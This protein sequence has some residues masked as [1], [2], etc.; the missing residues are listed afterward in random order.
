MAESL[1]GSVDIKRINALLEKVLSVAD[2]TEYSTIID[3]AS[4]L[5]SYRVP[6]DKLLAFA[7]VGAGYVVGPASAINNGI[8]V[9]DTISGKLIKDS[10]VLISDL[11]LISN[12]ENTTLDTS[13]TKY[14]TN[15]LVKEY[16]D[17][18]VVGL[19]DDRGNYNASGNVF[20]ST[21]GSGTAGAILKG[22]IWYIS[23]GGTLG[24]SLVGVGD[25]VRALSDTPGQASTNWDILETN[26]GYIPE[27]AAN[28]DASGGYVGLTGYAHNFWN[29]AKTFLTTVVGTATA[30][31]AITLPNKDGMIAL[32]DDIVGGASITDQTYAQLAVLESGSLLVKG[33]LYRVTN[34]ITKHLIP[35]TSVIRSASAIEPLIFMAID[36]NKFA[37]QAYSQL[38]PKDIIHYNFD[39]NSCEDGTWSVPLQRYTG[40]TAR[41]GKITY[42]KDTVYNLETHYDWRNV[43]FR[44]WAVD[45]V[46]WASGSDYYNGDVAKGS[47]GHIYKCL[48]DISGGT[49][50]PVLDTI[51][52]ML[53]LKRSTDL[54]F[55]SW[56]NDTSSF[57]VFGGITPDNLI[58]RDTTPGTDFIDLYTFCISDELTNS[59]GIINGTGAGSVGYGFNFLS[60]GAINQG[61]FEYAALPVKGGYNNIVFY[62]KPDTNIEKICNNNYFGDNCYNATI[63]AYYM[64]NNTIGTGFNNNIIF[65]TCNSNNV[66]ITFC[67]NITNNGFSGN[68]IA[69][70]CN[71]NVF[72]GPFTQNSIGQGFLGNLI[73]NEFIGNNIA[74][75]V[76][77]NTFRGQF[78]YNKVNSYIL[79]IVSYSTIRD[80]SFEANLDLRFEDLSATTILQGSYNKTVFKN[81]A[82]AYRLSYINGANAIINVA[83]GS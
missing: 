5:T 33:Q 62:L 51:N 70:D 39:D 22:D 65:K 76:Y 2:L 57:S 30:P 60:L 56:T 64:Y 15:R 12:K 68:V 46:A 24:G 61:Y 53:L 10:A 35:N 4:D 40:G 20:P 66:G 73:G 29:A 27:N 28:K 75:L 21:G 82:G 11:E 32:L 9:F 83:V 49:T 78:L 59:S 19:L 44:R 34:H 42:R 50:N 69:T 72:S 80:T 31:R 3:K 7:G 25:S 43:K 52:W 6:L 8:A 14:P 47:D 23:V 13:A 67:N 26:I 1:T 55:Q 37:L 54:P 74:Y 45:A 36:V 58:I 41:T 79:V 81:S 16:V 18:S 48:I 71:G 17:T 38:Y 77:Y 63:S